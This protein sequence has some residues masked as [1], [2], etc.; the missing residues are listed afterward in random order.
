MNICEKGPLN[1][2]G[3]FKINETWESEIKTILHRFYNMMGLVT[4]CDISLLN[5]LKPKP[6]GLNCVS[7]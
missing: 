5:S 1:D 2:M 4:L 6:N 3:V 7:S